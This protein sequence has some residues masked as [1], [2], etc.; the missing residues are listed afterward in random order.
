MTARY[1]SREITPYLLKALHQ[2]PVVVMTG[3]RQ[4]GKSTFL[5]QAP[6][7]KK[8][9]YISLDDFTSLETAKRNPEFFL[10]EDTP[11]TIDEV[12]RA[13]EILLAI[14]RSVDKKD[15]PGRFLL[16]GSANFALLKEVSES[17]A[18]R[19][20]YLQ[21]HPFTRREIHASLQKE[22]AI[23]TFFKNP[24]EIPR[25][26]VTP[27]HPKEILTGGMPRV[28]L[29]Q[30]KDALLWFRGFEQT[31]LERDIRQ[32]S[33]VAD[34]VSFHTLLQMASLRIG[35]ILN[36][37]ELARDAKLNN[38]TAGR[39]LNLLETS[40][41]LQKLQPYLKNKTSR[42][43]KSPKLYLSDSGLACYLSGVV[44]ISQ[45][46]QERLWGALFENFVAQ[47]LWGILSATWPEARL[48]YWQIP[49]RHEVD[50][51]VEV[52]HRDTLAIEV[53]SGTRWEERDLT[54]LRNFLSATPRCRAAVLAYNGKEA[55][56]L[57]KRL[58]VLPVAWLI[59]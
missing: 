36:Q 43:I 4:V 28:A 38:M 51:V 8:R 31:Y 57:D 50:F 49:A 10:E 27:I 59:S 13:P 18:G 5:Q 25:D 26:P 12:Q 48:Y 7:L 42:L 45:P 15:I 39:Y 35:Q 47:N 9:R 33:Q 17:L 54:P 52:N 55:A 41:V 16:S 58:W 6:E 40:F 37:S 1:L 23:K 46:S 3:M 11:V 34:L 14:K 30:E 19:A 20:L 22:P 44:D 21:M 53:K 2:M 56:Q 24:E 32:L 29:H